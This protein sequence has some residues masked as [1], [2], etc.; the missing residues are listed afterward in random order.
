VVATRLARVGTCLKY[1]KRAKKSP[2][3]V[4]TG[5]AP[6]GQCLPQ[7]P[8]HGGKLRGGGA[9]ERL[10]LVSKH[11]S[12]QTSWAVSGLVRNFKTRKRGPGND[13]P[14]SRV[15]LRWDTVY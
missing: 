11:A 6:V 1:Q 12:A 10:A 4:T 8:L 3:S 15:G 7:T 14:R 9:D 2:Y 13:F 5:L